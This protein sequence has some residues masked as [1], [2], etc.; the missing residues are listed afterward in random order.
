MDEVFGRLVRCA[1]VTNFASLSA[2]TL[3]CLACS[4]DDRQ[5]VPAD[6]GPPPLG[7]NDGPASD[8]STPLTSPDP[9]GLV[10]GCAD[11]D[12]DGV[13][14]CTVTL[15]QNPSFASDTSD[16]TA[17]ASVSWAWAAHNALDDVPSGSGKLVVETP[18]GSATQCVTVASSHE[19]VIAYASVFVEPSD[20]GA[21]LNE[22]DVSATFFAST[23]CSG[24]SVGSFEAPPSA[25]LGAWT[26]VQAGGYPATPIGS[27]S[28]ALNA[29]KDSAAPAVTAYFDNVLLRTKASD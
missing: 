21:S 23:D 3:G 15:A 12:T 14:D 2:V 16:W 7:R 5:L 18:R 10:D 9:T 20:D 19:V 22:A 26:V 11:L 1:T 25:V 8:G 28:L 29:I 17:A 27:I 13:G 4:V 24:A 6:S